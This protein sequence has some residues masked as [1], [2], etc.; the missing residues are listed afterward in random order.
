MV[1]NKLAALILQWLWIIWNLRYQEV[2]QECVCL[3]IFTVKVVITKDLNRLNSN[4]LLSWTLLCLACEIQFM[5]VLH[6]AIINPLS[7]YLT[8]SAGGHVAQKLYCIE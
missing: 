7:L 2:K 3:D 6:K 4:M 5:D 1:A 8:D